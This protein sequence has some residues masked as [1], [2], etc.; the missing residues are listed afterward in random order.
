M[1]E[2]RAMSSSWRENAPVI[3]QANAAANAA[4]MS[5]PMPL[6]IALPVLLPMALLFRYSAAAAAT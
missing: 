5:I 1:S 6:P 3:S 4:A 2:E